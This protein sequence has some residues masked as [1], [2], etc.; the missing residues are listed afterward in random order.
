MKAEATL[1]HS[2]YPTLHRHQILVKATVNLANVRRNRL[3]GTLTR[4]GFDSVPN[5]NSV[6]FFPFQREVYKQNSGPYGS[7]PLDAR[8]EVVRYHVGPLMIALSLFQAMVFCYQKELAPNGYYLRL[9]ELDLFCGNQFVK[10]LKGFRSSI[11]HEDSSTINDQLD[12]LRSYGGDEIERHL[13]NGIEIFDSYLQLLL[14][15]R[16]GGAK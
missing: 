1:A 15:I 4:M 3:D 2:Y 8:R 5:T 12:F 14:Y 16:D 11:I 9:S 10:M 13:R 7:M 6:D